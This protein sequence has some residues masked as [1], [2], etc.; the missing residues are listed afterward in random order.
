MPKKSQFDS[1]FGEMDIS[2]MPK[3]KDVSKEQPKKNIDENIYHNNDTDENNFHN[4]KV[5]D[6]DNI[7][8]INFDKYIIKKTKKN[9]K[10]K[11]KRTNLRLS[12]RNSYLLRLVSLKSGVTIN[13]YADYIFTQYF[14]G[15]NV[16]SRD[17]EAYEDE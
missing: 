12:P 16:D 8:T 13:D 1:M 10:T 4:E 5:K 11:A 14:E 17:Y 3:T 7:S 2:D 15:L 6:D 9:S